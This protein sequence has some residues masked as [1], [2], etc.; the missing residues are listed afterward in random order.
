MDEVI[1]KNP[2]EAALGGLPGMRNKVRAFVDVTMR[3]KELQEAFK[4]EVGTLQYHSER[5]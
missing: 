2:K 1:A 3:S 4:P 5:C